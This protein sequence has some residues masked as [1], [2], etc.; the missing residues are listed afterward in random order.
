[1]SLE[2]PEEYMNNPMG[3]E[4]HGGAI[5]TCFDGA[6]S[7]SLVASSAYFGQG[8]SPSMSIKYLRPPMAGQQIDI[9]SEILQVTRRV[10]TIYGVMRRCSDGA[11][12]AV[13]L[14]EKMNMTKPESRE[15]Q[16]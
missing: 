5:A 3:K 12:L 13:C 2:L 4:I 16:S 14:H 9:E 15:S 10:A 1:M 11:V 8:V 7:L 6:T